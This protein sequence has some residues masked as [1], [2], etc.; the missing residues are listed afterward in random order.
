MTKEISVINQ[1]I[2]ISSD[3]LNGEFVI[4]FPKSQVFSYVYAV[5]IA[6]GADCYAEGVIGKRLH[7]AASFNS[8]VRS[9]RVI[10]RIVGMLHHT[11]GVQIL[12]HGKDSDPWKVREILSCY[13]GSIDASKREVYCSIKIDDAGI[14]LGPLSENLSYSYLPCRL[15]SGKAYQRFGNSIGS[16]ADIIDAIATDADVKWCPSY[17]N[18]PPALIE[19]LKDDTEGEIGS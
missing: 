12:V 15:L 3:F 19:S 1:Q 14:P 16:K 17:K 13:I 11:K 5:A 7:H 6:K 10:S 9:A 2:E 18:K 4:V 8:I